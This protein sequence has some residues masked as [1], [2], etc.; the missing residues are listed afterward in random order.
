MTRYSDEELQ[1]CYGDAIN[2]FQMMEETR[3]QGRKNANFNEVNEK[4]GK[5]LNRG[6]DLLKTFRKCKDEQTS[7][8][9][10]HAIDNEVINAF[11]AMI[12]CSVLTSNQIDAIKVF[13]EAFDK[14]IS[15]KKNYLSGKSTKTNKA[16][17]PQTVKNEENAETSTENEDIKKAAAAPSS[18]NAD[19]EKWFQKVQNIINTFTDIQEA[20]NEYDVWALRE[21]GNEMQWN[22]VQCKRYND[23]Q[24]NI[25]RILSKRAENNAADAK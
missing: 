23:A 4:F 6:Y 8:D 19:Y 16:N 20:M 17:N 5:K 22:D 18:E 13:N 24:H 21:Y 7:I 2:E 3:C 25:T 10:I 15:D 14:A 11:Q 1:V 9:Y 12:D